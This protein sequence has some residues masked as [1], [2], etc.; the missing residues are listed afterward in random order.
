MVLSCKRRA[1]PILSWAT[2][3]CC[4]SSP[5]RLS[6]VGTGSPPGCATAVAGALP[7]WIAALAAL[8]E[9]AWC[10]VR[11]SVGGA[12]VGCTLGSEVFLVAVAAHA[13]SVWLSVCAPCVTDSCSWWG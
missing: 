9:S 1:L 6:F 13:D 2:A 10:S 11:G 8:R 4:S 7:R 5:R 3:N 12:F